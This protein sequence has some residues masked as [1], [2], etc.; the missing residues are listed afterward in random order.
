MCIGTNVPVLCTQNDSNEERVEKHVQILNLS[1][2]EA[3][4]TAVFK[5]LCGIIIF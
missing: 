5:L 2:L 1:S 3:K 4:N